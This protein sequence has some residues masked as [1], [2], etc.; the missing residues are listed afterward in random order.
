MNTRSNTRSNQRSNQPICRYGIKCYRKNKEHIDTFKHSNLLCDMPSEL[1]C[2]CGGGQSCLIDRRWVGD[3]CHEDDVFT[4]MNIPLRK[5]CI[6]SYT[7]EQENA[8]KK[9][10]E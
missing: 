8:I 3:F 4:K 5:T 1:T 6:E 9:S 10:L 2:R 7:V